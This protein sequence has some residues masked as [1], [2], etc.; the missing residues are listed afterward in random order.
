MQRR[1]AYRARLSRTPHRSDREVPLAVTRVTSHTAGDHLV[2]SSAMDDIVRKH[3][4][5][6]HLKF[7][8]EAGREGVREYLLFLH[9]D[10]G[11]SPAAS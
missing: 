2:T 6:V 8:D 5:D 9:R 7:H 1:V 10:R 4:H 3:V 11:M